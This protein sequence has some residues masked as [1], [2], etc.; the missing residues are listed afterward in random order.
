MQTGWF[1]DESSLQ[2]R[3]T[4]YI[5][6]FEGTNLNLGSTSAFI[7]GKLVTGEI[8]LPRGYHTFSTTFNKDK[9]FSKLINILSFSVSAFITGIKHIKKGDKNII[10]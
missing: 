9:P 7:N 4:I 10:C 6:S 2:V 5:D 8:L 3:T 1:R